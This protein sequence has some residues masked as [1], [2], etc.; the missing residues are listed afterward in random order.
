MA[1]KFR[2]LLRPIETSHEVSDAIVKAILCLHNF[3]LEDIRGQW[4]ITDYETRTMVNG[5]AISSRN[6]KL[7]Q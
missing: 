5:A 6:S 3:L 4:P 1:A 7:Q 2:I